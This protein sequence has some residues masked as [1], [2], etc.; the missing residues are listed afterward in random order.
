MRLTD[1]DLKQI[2][3]E[4]L[5][6]LL[7][8]QLLYLSE[9]RLAD[10]RTARERLMQMPQNS[11]RPSGSDAPWGQAS[12]ADAKSRSDAVAERVEK[13]K[14]KKA[15]KGSKSERPGAEE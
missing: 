9:K 10:L 3:Q 7:P 6:S 1:H 15:D 4:Y 14:A 5:A 11:S 13:A 12:F 8:E 2:N